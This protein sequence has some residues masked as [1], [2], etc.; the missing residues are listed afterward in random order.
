MTVV[1]RNLGE[2]RDLGGDCEGAWRWA[3]ESC[4]RRDARNKKAG[5]VRHQ[6]RGVESGNRPNRCS[7]LGVTDPCLPHSSSAASDRLCLNRL[8]WGAP[9]AADA[10]SGPPVDRGLASTVPCLG[11]RF[12]GG[13]Y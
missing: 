9:G 8:N 1:N 12:G 11:P 4:S 7:T 3:E 6:T 2:D 5:G 13:P 10:A